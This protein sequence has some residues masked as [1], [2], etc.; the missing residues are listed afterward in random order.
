[1]RSTTAGSRS[2]SPV[3]LSTKTAIGTPQARCRLMHQSGLVSIIERSRVLPR[4]GTN[5]VA[6]MA[7]SA[8]ARRSS[9]P[10]M[11]MNHWAVA[12]KIKGALERQECG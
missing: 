6:S 5:V 9:S 7:R 3:R 8:V 1:M 4:S 2:G 12:R 10:S 11:G